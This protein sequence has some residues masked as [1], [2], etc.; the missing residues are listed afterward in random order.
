MS[1]YSPAISIIVVSFSAIIFLTTYDLS[2]TY[3]I[4]VFKISDKSIYFS[5]NGFYDNS[6]NTNPVYILHSLT[7]SFNS[8][9]V[10]IKAEATKWINFYYSS[11]FNLDYLIFVA[12]SNSSNAVYFRI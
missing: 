3:F 4:I 2:F 10:L 7:Q 6:N 9:D 8:T 1:I 11:S 12:I 5:N